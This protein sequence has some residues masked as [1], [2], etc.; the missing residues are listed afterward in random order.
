M[1]FQVPIL[2]INLIISL[3]E[4]IM[5][6]KLT[7][8]GHSALSIKTNGT[9]VLVDPFIKDNPLT[10]VDL[11]SLQADYILVSH[12]HEDHV[13]DT[14]AIAKNTG[15]TI[16]TN[17]EIANWFSAQG[18]TNVHPQHI[19]GGYTHEFGYVKLTH[20]HHGSSLPDGSY[21]GNPCGFL[22]KTLDTTLYLAC[23]TGLFGDMKLI[24]EEGVDLAVLPIGDNFTM[25]P[26]DALRAVKMI[27][28]TLALPA[29]YNTWPLIEQNAMKWKQAVEKETTTKVY[30]LQSGQSINYK[31]NQDD[32]I[33]NL[34]IE[35]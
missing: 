31:N 10:S 26:Q 23:D 29:H 28:P 11:H 19:G 33:D 9:N 1:M 3:K 18:I 20:A 4:I 24:G 7:Y 6:V 5:S 13:G 21:G 17:L 25:G 34:F 8:H 30:V 22:I 14:I 35:T 27:K 2:W 12:G 32:G 15:A 16:I